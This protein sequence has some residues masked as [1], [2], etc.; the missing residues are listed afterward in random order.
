MK[1]QLYTGTR[2]YIGDEGQFSAIWK[3]PVD[4]PVRITSTGIVGD[5]QADGRVHGGAE[6]A[7]HHYAGENYAKLAARFPTIAGSLVVGSIGENVSTLGLDETSVFIGD[8][9]RLGTAVVQVS[10]PRKP[11]WKID[12]RYEITGL[13][14]FIVESGH[15]GWYYRVLEEGEAAP[16]D[17]LEHLDRP[18]GAITLD[19]LWTAWHRH[20][21]DADRLR[22]IAG[23]PGLT[24]AWIRKIDERLAWLAANS[25]T[26]TKPA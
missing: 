1:I 2:R 3:Q 19:A 4:G 23:A 13:T 17:L 15:T 24:P 9:F 6:K 16:G 25:G 8:I 20:R 7:V 5:E 21:P 18:A 12:A 14:A 10:Q 26:T 11:C 22:Q